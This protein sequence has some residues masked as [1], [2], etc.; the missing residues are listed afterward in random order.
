MSEQQRT[1][2]EISAEILSRLD[3]ASEYEALGVR[4]RGEPRASGM[5]SAF[6]YGRDDRS[7]SAFI[8][9]RTG[10]YGD[11]GGKDAAAYTMSLWDFS[12]KVGKFPDWQA[13]RKA[14]AEKAGVAIGREKKAEGKSDWRERLEL[15]S[16]ET[17][18][19]HVLALRWCMKCKPGVT[20]EAIK[21]AGGVLAYYPCWIDKKTGEKKRRKDVR[22][23]VAIPCYGAWFIDADPVAWVIWDVTGQEFDVTPA[24]TPPTEPRI[25]AKMLSIG[26]TSG[27]TAGLSSLLML[28]DQDR[29][30]GIELVWKVEGPAD[31]LALWAA[32]PEQDRERV[33]VVTQA[34]GAS[35]DVHI[36]QA[37]LLAGL[38]VAVVPDCDTAGQFGAEKWC[39]ALDGIAG[40]TRVVRLPWEV[41][42]SH[43]EDVRDF[44]TGVPVSVSTTK[45]EVT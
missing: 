38:R 14:Y 32:I 1:P 42:P 16:W 19:N 33:A 3:V 20:V 28:C 11:S 39:R 45:G 31:M 22:Q 30:A 6:A 26:A 36:H 44:L 29:R 17:P 9:I 5:V 27:A 4:L 25:M 35:A 12:V 37:K 34:G 41:K 8:N 40:E 43:G 7:P 24:D 23:V 18:G 13:A 15:Q 21:A 10:V 2:Q